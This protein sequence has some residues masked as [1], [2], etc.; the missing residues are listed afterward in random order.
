MQ[1]FFIFSLSRVV[2]LLGP[3]M[4]R[5]IMNKFA[6][7]RNYFTKTSR[8]FLVLFWVVKKLDLQWLD[9]DT[10][11]KKDLSCDQEKIKSEDFY[12]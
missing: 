1:G 4:R 7:R 11:S 10:L 8:K 12:F 9:L 6:T 5:Y 2:I 3:W